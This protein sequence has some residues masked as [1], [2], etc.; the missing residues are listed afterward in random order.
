MRGGVVFPAVRLQHILVEEDSTPRPRHQKKTT[1]DL[2]RRSL[3][4]PRKNAIPPSCEGKD[5]QARERR[6]WRIITVVRPKARSAH[7]EGSGT[8]VNVIVPSSSNWAD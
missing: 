4:P 8:A 6:R 2:C 7:V 3:F 1:A 5:C